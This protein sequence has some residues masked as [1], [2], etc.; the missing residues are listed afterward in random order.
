ML[1]VSKIP[2]LQILAPTQTCWSPASRASDS[3]L[4]NLIVYKLQL[5]MG[6]HAPGSWETYC[7]APSWRA[8]PCS[9]SE[10]SRASEWLHSEPVA[11]LAEVTK[12]WDGSRERRRGKAVG[13]SSELVGPSPQNPE[14]GINLFNL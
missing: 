13:F 4:W 14:L 9:R 3:E 6:Y 11:E 1:F 5:Q 8:G 12:S 7:I 2:R 10:P